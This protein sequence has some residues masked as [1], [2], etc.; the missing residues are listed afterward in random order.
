MTE[1]DSSNEKGVDNDMATL[2][3]PNHALIIKQNKATEFIKALKEQRKPSNYW[4]EC[5]KAKS[6]FSKEQIEKMKKMC[7]G[8]TNE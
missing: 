4:E 6:A 7:N 1:K 2:I 3:T 5:Y 8:D